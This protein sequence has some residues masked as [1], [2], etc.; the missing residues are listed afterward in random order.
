MITYTYKLSL[1]GPRTTY[2]DAVFTPGDVSAYRLGIVFASEGKPYDTSGCTLAVKARR[3]DGVVVT[4][5]GTV[6]GNGT[7]YYEV[8]SDVYA[9]PGEL[10]LEI[11]LCT[12][13]GGYITTHELICR[14]REGHGAGDLTA[15]NT[16]PILSQLIERAMQAEQAAQRAAEAAAEA[17]AVSRQ[18]FTNALAGT[19]IGSSIHISD[20][21]PIEHELKVSVSGIDD[22]DT[23][24][25]TKLGKN[26]FDFLGAAKKNSSLTIYGDVVGGAGSQHLKTNFTIPA[27]MNGK[28]ISA[29]CMLRSEGGTDSTTYC[30]I[31]LYR[32][33]DKTQVMAENIPANGSDY[34][35]ATF[36][37]EVQEGD[38]IGVTYGGSGGNNQIIYAK[39]FQIEIADAPTEYETYTEEKYTVNLDGSVDGIISAYPV[40]NLITDTQGAVIDVEYNRD[41]N[42]V[43][44]K[45][46][47]AIISLGGNV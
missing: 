5:G 6:A 19:A 14:V 28:T 22:S 40:T 38:V 23:A 12:P 24:T 4:D 13:V 10:S 18:R 43:I 15:E 7:V 35:K 1:Q 46:T 39:E 2:T 32:A 26:L 47:N 27:S 9:V 20:V 42:K 45:L 37:A 36:T 41:S 34:R 17:D 11:A 3:A 25:L 31:R 16:T 21:S 8:K 30:S 29:S 44:E 33:S